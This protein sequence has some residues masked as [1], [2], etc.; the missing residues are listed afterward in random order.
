MKNKKIIIGSDFGPHS[1]FAIKTGIS[2]SKVLNL[3]PVFFHVAHGTAEMESIDALKSELSIKLKEIKDIF[4][5]D[6]KKKLKRQILD[7]NENIEYTNHI[8]IEFGDIITSINRRFNVEDA[9]LLVIGA[10][11]KEEFE[12]IFVGNTSLKAIKKLNH[13]VLVATN[14]KPIRP[15]KIF[16]ATDLEE[17]SKEVFK[18]VQKLSHVFGAEVVLGHVLRP[19]FS[20]Y[21]N[22]ET[23]KLMEIY[24]KEN[25]DAVEKIEFFEA[26]FKSLNIPFKSKISLGKSNHIGKTLVDIIDEESPDLVIFGAGQSSNIKKFFLGGVEEYLVHHLDTSFLI[27]KGHSF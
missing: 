22:H 5:N 16:W 27:V 12:S 8:E 7:L 14:S 20:E 4:K 25:S 10:H 1:N 17:Y 6:L 2:W 11:G 18:W 24:K 13:P 26:Q 23:N 3:N 19:K 9:L 21:F 15:K